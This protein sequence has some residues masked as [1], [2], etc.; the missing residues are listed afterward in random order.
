MTKQRAQ[1][2]AKAL[3]AA[4]AKRKE[5]ARAKANA[6][7]PAGSTNFHQP[8]STGN[9]AVAEKAADAWLIIRHL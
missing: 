3:T 8:W 7:S 4:A 5:G 6:R 1:V 2:V 9:E